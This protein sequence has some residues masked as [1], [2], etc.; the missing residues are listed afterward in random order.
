[1]FRIGST[2]I[3]GIRASAFDAD[4]RNALAASIVSSLDK[5]SDRSVTVVITYFQDSGTAQRTL[6]TSAVV[7]FYEIAVVLEEY[8]G[9][10]G[11]IFGVIDTTLKEA[12]QSSALLNNM[13]DILTTTKGEDV[14]DLSIDSISND[15]D[16]VVFTVLSTPVPSVHP[17]VAPTTGDGRNSGG[18]SI[19][20]TV[21]IV[22]I[23]VAVASVLIAVVS[24]FFC[25]A[26]KGVIP[27]K[28]AVVRHHDED[29]AADLSESL[30]YDSPVIGAGE[31]PGSL[32]LAP[33]NHE[34]RL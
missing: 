24:Y 23:A 20:N 21:I 25:V 7:V 11:S 31:I 12:Q 19:R 6:S 26:T 4:Y 32:S 33:N 34:E 29:Y 16:A 27:E 10:S 5:G 8:G 22:I 3:A 28:L 1:M 13:K 14:P 17:T 18:E 2:V 9:D 30:K 15:E